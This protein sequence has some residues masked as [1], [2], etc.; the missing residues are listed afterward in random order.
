MVMAWVIWRQHEMMRRWWKG[1]V[2]ARYE[3]SFSVHSGLCSLFTQCLLLLVVPPDPVEL[4]ASCAA[5]KEIDTKQV[6]VLRDDDQRVP[7]PDQACSR[8]HCRL[9][10]AEFLCWS[11]HISKT[12][13]NQTPLKHRGPEENRFWTCGV[14]VHRSQLGGQHVLDLVQNPVIGRSQRGHD[15]WCSDGNTVT[16]R[17]LKLAR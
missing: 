6:P 13:Y 15:C 9:G 7:G 2:H 14:V 10:G 12:S 17:N 11:S 5:E 3:V 1:Q 16:E 8:Q 4:G